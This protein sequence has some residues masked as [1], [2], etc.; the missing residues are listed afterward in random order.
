LAG[1]KHMHKK[2]NESKSPKRVQIPL[3]NTFLD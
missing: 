2:S 3:C 1:K